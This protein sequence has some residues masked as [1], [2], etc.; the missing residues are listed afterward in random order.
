MCDVLLLLLRW[1]LL[2]APVHQVIH[3]HARVLLL[4]SLLV[5]GLLRLMVMVLEVLR[6]L[7]VEVLLVRRW[8]WRVL[9]ERC[10]RVG[11]VHRQERR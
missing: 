1:R 9:G 8:R 3:S 2:Q 5:V 6:V 7:L 10:H 11:A 4:L